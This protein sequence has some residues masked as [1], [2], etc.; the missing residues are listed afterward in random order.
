[1]HGPQSLTKS[2]H[3]HGLQLSVKKNMRDIYRRALHA[4]ASRSP[5]FARIIYILILL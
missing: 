1:M 5:C 3:L 4:G 2:F